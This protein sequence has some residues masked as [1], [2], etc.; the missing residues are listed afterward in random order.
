[1]RITLV[2][3]TYRPEANGVA[4]TLGRLVD[5]LSRHGHQVELVTPTLKRDDV[6]ASLSLL[7]LPGLPLPGYPAVRFGLPAVR[8]LVAE[9]GRHRPDV[10]YVA[11]QGPLGWAAV[12]AARRLGLPVISGYHTHFSA[13]GEHYGLGLAAPLVDSYLRRFHRRTRLTL[14]PT[15]Q[16]AAQ[17]R[18]AGFGDV[19][20]LSR[21]VDTRLFQPQRRC[22]ELRRQWGLLPGSPVVLYVGRIAAEKN[23]DLAVR[24]F[25]AI[26]RSTPTARFVLV[27]DGPLKARLAADNPDF[28]F[29]G[30]QSGEALARHYASADL[31]LFPSLTDTFGNV[32]LEAMASGL[33]V[34]AFDHGAAAE[35]ISPFSNGVTAPLGNADR[36]VA[37]AI[38]LARE[39]SLRHRFGALARGTVNTLDWDTVGARFTALLAAHATGK[40]PSTGPRPL[41]AAG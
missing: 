28:V 24:A 41:V 13:Y 31:F 25:R 6:P 10:I 12:R 33:P 38:L 40:Q 22:D 4:M 2:T 34:V 30:C 18:D 8:R 1:M 11:T 29:T 14:A 16:L 36:F 5:Y 15:Q 37:L 7:T 26:Q 17:L 27:G 23:L 35:H 21:G 19:E 20:V 3:E 9:W 32:V 39:P